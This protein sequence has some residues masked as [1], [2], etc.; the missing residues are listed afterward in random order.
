MFPLSTSTAWR[1]PRSSHRNEGRL[2][3]RVRLLEEAGQE[4]PR[5]GRRQRLHGAPLL[6]RQVRLQV[7]VD[8]GGATAQVRGEQ[9]AQGLGSPP[10]EQGPGGFIRLGPALLLPP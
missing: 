8:V 3:A 2:P 5:R 4:G 10:L 1:C 7:P 6:P 9:R